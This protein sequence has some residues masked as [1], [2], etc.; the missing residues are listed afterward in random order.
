MTIRELLTVAMCAAATNVPAQNDSLRTLLLNDVV[1]MGT[2]ASNDAPFAVTELNQRQMSGQASTGRELPMLFAQTPGVMA[3]SDNGL[4]IG[5]TYMRIRGA[6]DSRINVSIDGVP[7][8]S[9]EDECVFW[10]NMN[11]YS[12]LLGGAQIQ[13]G[14][15]TS[16]SGDGA[17]GGNISLTTKSPLERPALELNVSYGSYNTSNV[18]ASVSSGLMFNHLIAD[19]AYHATATDGY[20][21]GTGGKSGSYYAGLTWYNTART[22]T[23]RYKNIGNFE[24]TGQ[25][26]NGVVAGNDDYSMNVYNGVESYADM[27][28]MG[29]GRFNSLYERFVENWSD[30]AAWTTERY[31]MADGTLWKKSTDNYWQDHNILSAAWR[32]SDKWSLSGALRYTYDYGYYNEFRYDNK[33]KK[34]GLS[35]FLRSDGTTVTRTDFVRKKGLGSDTYGGFANFNYKSGNFDVVFGASTQ[36][37]KSRHFGRLTYIADKEMA[38][39][40]LQNADYEYYKSSARKHDVSAF[41]KGTYHF[42][43]HVSAFAD[44][45]YRL[46]KYKTDGQNDKFYALADGTYRN[47]PLDI[48]QT[49]NFVNPKIGLSYNNEGHQAYLSVAVS[50]REPERNNFTD[51]GSYPLPMSEMLLDYEAGY[52]YSAPRWHVGGNIYYMNYKDQLVQTGQVSDIGELLTTNV[53]HSY[54]AGI[55]MLAGYEAARWLS[56]E[57]NAALST[58]KISDFDEYVD[59]Y[60]DDWN[61]LQPV[62]NHYDNSTLAFSPSLL[63]NGFININVGKLNATWH[64]NY[65]SRQYLDNTESKSRSLPSFSQSDITASYTL[66]LDKHIYGIREAVFGVSLNNL[67]NRHYAASGWVYSAIVGNTHPNDNR[68][69]QTGYTP[70]AGFAAMVTLTVKF[71]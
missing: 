33:L 41:A 66:A 3:W 62:V 71:F 26:W 6:S 64:T 16:Q 19:G 25:A 63:L 32:M 21:H 68:Y 60:D 5:T 61:E 10:A 49:Y 48:N 11:S 7:L 22:L 23:L 28:E 40:Y 59:A 53:A 17:F 35:D 31:S 57:G 2:R 46:V 56:F 55:E 1:V 39:Y 43:P 47:Q 67:F 30:A 20:L 18:G 4:G 15:G 13:R 24:K 29:L 27:Y 36:Y 54:R 9:P 42:T 14:V 50:H 44:M 12:Y 37:F 8:N 52:A 34:F 70:M 58:N 65:V 38:E 51:N 45:Q 69:Y